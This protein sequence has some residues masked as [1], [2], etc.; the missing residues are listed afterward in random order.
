M[1]DNGS[2]A[3]ILRQ[4]ILDALKRLSPFPAYRMPH[5]KKTSGVRNR[6]RWG[7]PKNGYT[8][9][10][11]RRECER[12]LNQLAADQLDFTASGQTHIKGRARILREEFIASARRRREEF[13]AVYPSLRKGYLE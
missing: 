2:M 1:L 4:Q 12:R 6:T 7:R 3:F 13:L 8:P 5:E 9:H 10:Q 11:G